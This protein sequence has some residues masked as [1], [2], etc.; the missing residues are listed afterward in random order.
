MPQ[1][2]AQRGLARCCFSKHDAV[3]LPFPTLPACPHKCVCF[4]PL[5]S[6][7]CTATPPLIP[8]QPVFFDPR[9]LTNLEL[10]DRL[11]SLAPITDMKVGA[12]T[13]AVVG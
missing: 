9:A 11:D 3:D 5:Q 10:L 13:C 2:P 4:G 1:P 8:P 6:P 7:R 12:L